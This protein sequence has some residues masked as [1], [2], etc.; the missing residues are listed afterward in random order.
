MDKYTS[1]NMKSYTTKMAIVFTAF[2]VVL[3]MRWSLGKV[4]TAQ[5]A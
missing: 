2:E 1:R 4:A 3:L 5:H